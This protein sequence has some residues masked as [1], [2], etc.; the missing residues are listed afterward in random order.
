MEFLR[1]FTEFEQALVEVLRSDGVEGS[2]AGVGI[3][4]M[5][6]MV[7]RADSALEMKTERLRAVVHIRNKVVHQ[8]TVALS[9]DTLVEAFVFLS[10]LTMTLKGKLSE[11]TARS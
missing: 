2:R 5:W 7:A 6:H 10:D 4:E 3:A 8:D 1:A 9:A 11:R